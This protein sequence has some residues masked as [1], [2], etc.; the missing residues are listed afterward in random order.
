MGEAKTIPRA[1]SV[2]A[3][4]GFVLF[5]MLFVDD[6]GRASKHVVPA[7]MRHYEG[8]SGMYFADVVLPAFLFMVGMSVPFALQGRVEKG[9]P[10]GKTLLHVGERTA[11]LL[12]LG[13]IIVNGLADS[14]M[15]GWS[16]ELWSV[17]TTLSAILAFSAIK[18]S[19]R[20]TPTRA[21]LVSRL[22]TALRVVGLGALAALVFAFR[23]HDGHR[24]VSFSPFSIHAEWWG[25]L[26]QIGWAYLTA[27]LVYLVVRGRQA[28]LLVTTAL[29]Y[30]LYVADK[31]G[32]LGSFTL[33]PYLEVGE[34]MGSQSAIAVLGLAVST[35]VWQKSNEPTVA[36]NVRFALGLVAACG[37][38]AC[39]FQAKYVVSKDNA[40]PPWALWSS[41]IMVALWLAFYLQSDARAAEVKASRAM[42][43]L[44][45]AGQNVLLAYLLRDWVV[46]LLPFLH[47]DALYQSLASG[48]P[49][50]LF[51]SV[52]WSFAIVF[53]STGLNRL[54]F[55]VKL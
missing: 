12:L 27:S 35:T 1:L 40:T 4:R 36:Q 32:L 15:M 7:W 22:S 48:L 34:S 39:A 24:I 11:S 14:E 49:Q 18:I 8:A 19:R 25:I 38:A 37:A 45:T 52:A 17:L 50:A 20:S 31:K 53:A 10:L 5:T 55:L 41:S 3:L 42:T 51:R 33:S 54:G 47:V 43:A 26:G 29:L 16:A 28:A 30:C 9:E 13:V 2:D 44:A 6:L 46:A 21:R 23:G